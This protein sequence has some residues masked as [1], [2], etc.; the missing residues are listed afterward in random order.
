MGGLT[1][2][3]FALAIIMLIFF[4]VGLRTSAKAEKLAEEQEE[5]PVE[6]VGSK[7]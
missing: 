4:I 7:E 5:M 3:F 1:F 6:E 2:F